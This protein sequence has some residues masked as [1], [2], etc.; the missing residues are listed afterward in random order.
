MLILVIISN[1]VVHEIGIGR[2]LQGPGQQESGQLEI[3]PFLGGK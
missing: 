1:N 3:G 2:R